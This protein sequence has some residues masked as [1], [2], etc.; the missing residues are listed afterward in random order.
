MSQ[1]SYRSI[2][3]KSLYLKG[4]VFILAFGLVVSQFAFAL[5]VFALPNLSVEIYASPSS[6]NAPLNNV[7]LTAIVSGTATGDITYKF[8]CTNNGTWERTYTTSSTSYT[9]HDLCDY[10]S[11]GSYIAKIS[12]E[13]EELVFQGTTAI[14]VDS[15]ND[16]S[17][18][19]YANPFSGNAPLNN[20][21]LTANVSGAA[22]GNITYRFDCTNNGTWERTYTT[23]STSYTAHD[24]CDYS[25]PGSYTAKVKVERGGLSFQGTTAIV[26]YSEEEASLSIS[27]TGRNISQDKTSWVNTVNAEPGEIIEFRIRVTSSGDERAE[28]VIVSDDLPSKMSYFG[29]LRIDGSRVYGEDIEDGIDIGDLSPGKSKT[30]TFEAQIDD[31]DSFS[32]GTTSLINIGRVLADNVSQ[33]N[34]T[35]VVKVIKEKEEE[36]SLS[37]SKRGRNLTQGK[38]SWVNT[39]SAKPAEVIEFRIRV[40]SNGDEKAED[41]IVS[42]IL[43]SK[44]TYLGNLKI[45]GSTVSG[46]E[47]IGDGVDIGDLSPDKSKTITFK[48]IVATEKN[49]NFGTTSLVNSGMVRADNVSLTSDTCTVK[50]TRTQVAGAVTEV[51]TAATDYLYLSLLMVFLMSLCLYL[52]FQG[53]EYSQNRFT[54][55]LLR[56]CYMFKSFVFPGRR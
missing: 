32:S 17:V 38:T 13:R 51:I 49:F 18:V 44:M 12:V 2:F 5:V 53:I 54:K 11:P 40:T 25:S 41:V 34:D 23:S 4:G 30:I 52:I 48:A 26:V 43:P 24:L 6:G 55:R 35:A 9:A 27:K 21:D 33:V 16:L 47:D 15:G 19:L 10:S 50:V 20:V 29:D 8:D 7:D 36:A 31:E 28:D 45:D 22:T 1:T 56:R 42:D 39:I 14:F 46:A 37:V 3:L